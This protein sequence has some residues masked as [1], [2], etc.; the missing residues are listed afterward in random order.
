MAYSIDPMG[1]P[2][3]QKALGQGQLTDEDLQKI[4]RGP[5]S[6]FGQAGMGAGGG[7]GMGQ[8]AQV[9]Q[10]QMLQ[11]KTFGPS[12]NGPNAMLMNALGGGNTYQTSQGPIPASVGVTGAQQLGSAGGGSGLA[13]MMGK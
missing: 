9:P 3:M 13:A 10:P 11:S 4:F 12:G 6:P 5:N 8:L 7:L 2:F 1:I